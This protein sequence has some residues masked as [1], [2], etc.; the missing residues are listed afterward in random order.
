MNLVNDSPPPI[1][2]MVVE[3]QLLVLQ[4]IVALLSMYKEFEVVGEAADVPSAI[5]LHKKLTPDVTL[6]DLRLGAHSGVDFITAVRAQ[7]SRARFLVLTT[8]DGEAD[9]A[10][11]LQAGAQGYLL[12]GVTRGVLSEAIKAIHAGRRYVPHEIAERV[13]PQPPG[14]ELT[15][16]EQVVL[17]KIAEGL[18]N[19]EIAVALRISE[20]TVKSHIHSL[21][22]KLEVTDRTRALVVA[23]RRGLVRIH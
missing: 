17:E 10:R 3:D 21:F 5:A 4:G 20:A 18:N 11:A 15:E 13:L 1:R 8:F 2:I 22:A 14:S 12:K 16:R 7:E 19:K 23:T 6:V 9:V